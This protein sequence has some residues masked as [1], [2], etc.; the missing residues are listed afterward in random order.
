MHL[1]STKN[2]FV[3][4]RVGTLYRWATALGE[5]M[6]LAKGCGIGDP[7]SISFWIGPVSGATIR[8]HTYRAVRKAHPL[9]PSDII[10]CP[11]YRMQ[12]ALLATRDEGSFASAYACDP[13]YGALWG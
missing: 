6:T 8:A 4:Y 12:D 2:R 7:T 11:R 10:N 1:Y 5:G 3:A 9:S 13:P